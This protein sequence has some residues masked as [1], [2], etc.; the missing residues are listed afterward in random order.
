MYIKFGDQ[1]VPY[2]DLLTA[3]TGTDLDEYAGLCGFPFTMTISFINLG[4][5]T[6]MICY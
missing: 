1:L 3:D 4:Y 6:N 2:P 5:M